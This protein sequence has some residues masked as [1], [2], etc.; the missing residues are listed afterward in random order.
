MYSVQTLMC[1]CSTP[2]P[3]SSIH[4]EVLDSRNLLDSTHRQVVCIR[5][6]PWPPFT[7]A[8]LTVTIHATLLRVPCS[9]GCSSQA[10]C[11]RHNRRHP[12]YSAS[13]V[14]FLS[15]S[16]W[17]SM[18]VGNNKLLASAGIPATLSILLNPRGQ[19]FL[20]FIHMACSFGLLAAKAKSAPSVYRPASLPFHSCNSCSL[21]CQIPSLLCPLRMRFTQ[22]LANVL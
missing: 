20:F 13:L 17:P 16:L 9:P 2:C 11:C 5:R 14:R 4:A 10:S 21:L 3:S 7:L 18:H 8:R 22:P 19:F 15:L 12:R 6:R 1:F